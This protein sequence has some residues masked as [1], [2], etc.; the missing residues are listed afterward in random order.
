LPTPGSELGGGALPW[1][2]GNA[3]SLMFKK[4]RITY[5][6]VIAAYKAFQEIPIELAPVDIEM[7]LKISHDHRIYA[8]DSYMLS[9]A[10]DYKSPLLTLDRQLIK[11]AGQLKIRSLG[12]AL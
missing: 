8:Y 7:A 11:T 3:F 5:R 1:E 10:I 2:I 9:C 12:G 4:R 6:E